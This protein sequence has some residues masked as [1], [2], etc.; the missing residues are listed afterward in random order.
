M[1]VYYQLI[2]QVE[3]K[4]SS[5][6]ICKGKNKDD[7]GKDEVGEHDQT[8]AKFPKLLRLLWGRWRRLGQV[9]DWHQQEE[10]NEGEHET[11]YQPHVDQLYVGG[12]G[13]LVWDGLVEGVDD[14]HHGD[15]DGS[16]GLEVLGPEVEPALAD[17]HEAEGGQVGGE[18]VVLHPTLENQGHFNPRFSLGHLPVKQG[19]LGGNVMICFKSFKIEPASYPLDWVGEGLQAEEWRDPPHLLVSP[20]GSCRPAKY[21]LRR[22]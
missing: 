1:N 16:C 17:E 15:A 21:L 10:D 9:V 14:E 19:E 2:S 7:C 6:C 12:R 18:Q 22:C 20:I 8:L 4:G 13:D 3:D 5:D 11:K